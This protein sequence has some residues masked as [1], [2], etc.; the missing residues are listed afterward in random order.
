MASDE[1]RRDPEDCNAQALCLL[2]C[3]SHEYML[4]LEWN[5]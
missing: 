1:D 5:T 2:R 3:P 4:R